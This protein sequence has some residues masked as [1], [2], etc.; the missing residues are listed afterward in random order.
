LKL[1]RIPSTPDP[2]TLRLDSYV[3]LSRLPFADQLLPTIP[4]G[5]MLHD[6]MRSDWPILGNDRFPCCASSS[7]GHMVHHWTEANGHLVLLTEQEIIAAHGAL[8]GGAADKG[9][10][11]LDALKYW[12]KSGIGDH[13]IHSFVLADNQRD[14]L[15]SV[16]Y[17]FG[18]AYVGLNLP[19]FAYP[20]PLPANL[21]E[22]PAIPWEIPTN[23]PA[24]D[25]APN[26]NKGHCIAAI[27]YD[28]KIV[29]V[30]TWGTLKTMSWDFYLKYSSETYAVLSPDWL[31]NNESPSGFDFAAL[32]RDLQL[33]TRETSH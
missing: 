19:D 16:L 13:T 6:D 2:R 3:D 4:L 20:T 28:E 18:S 25:W 30:V 12:R 8:T 9:V 14:E 11:M 27:G 24:N 33:V 31:S 23:L 22:I 26:P 15:K 5:E 29:Y 1:G 7:A 21:A 10:T 17:I 32:Q